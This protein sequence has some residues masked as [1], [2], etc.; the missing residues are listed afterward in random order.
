MDSPVLKREKKKKKKKYWGW[1]SKYQQIYMSFFSMPLN[2]LAAYSDIEDKVSAH[3]VIV[4]SY[5]RA[6]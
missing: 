3:T 5:S 1:G 6:L 2:K 4:S